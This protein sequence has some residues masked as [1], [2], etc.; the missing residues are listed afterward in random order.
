MEFACD[1]C[2]RQFSTSYEAVTGRVYRIPCKCGNTIVLRFD[3]PRQAEPPPFPPRAASRLTPPPLPAYFRAMASAGGARAGSAMTP[4]EGAPA[5]AARSGTTPSA[6]S[7]PPPTHD[8]AALARLDPTASPEVSGEHPY[9]PSMSVPFAVAFAQSRRRA[10]LAGCGAGASA[11][12]VL[13]GAIA[14]MAWLSGPRSESGATTAQ[15]VNV[16]SKEQASPPPGVAIAT[17]GG[18]RAARDAPARVEQTPPRV[19]IAPILV[20][21]A[22]ASRPTAVDRK[23]AAAATAD[24]G[25]ADDAASAASDDASEPQAV[26][27]A[28]G[29]EAPS[30]AE[31]PNGPEAQTTGAEAQT[32]QE[33]GPAQEAAVA[34]TEA[35][36]RAD[37]SPEEPR[38]IALAPVTEPEQA[39]QPDNAPRAPAEEAAAQ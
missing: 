32:A 25:R 27:E 22:V 16:A 24:D 29:G 19:V 13:V 8:D 36:E 9:E 37:D 11:A 30:G 20:K 34:A 39:S 33:Q 28:N 17:I 1:R 23:K 21:E 12:T 38:Q 7:A 18:G 10:F 26:A 35:R 15:I 14:L 5:P 3:T 31:A 2:R 6:A 4:G